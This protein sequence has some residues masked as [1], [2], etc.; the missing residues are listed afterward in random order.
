M[1]WLIPFLF[2]FTA[3]Q[4]DS[5]TT[6]NLLPNAGDGVDWGS[7]STEQ[8]NPGNSSGTV[9]NGATIN[10]F[11]VTCPASQ[12]NCGYKYSVG[13]D[14]EV[15]GTATL[16]VDDIPLT[17]NTRTQEMLDNGITL[18]SY[19]DVANCDSQPGN[20]EGK[21][22]N[23]DSHTVTIQLKDSS[24]DV[25]STTTQTRTEIVGFQG[26]CNGYP[27]NNSG[28]QAANCGQ[29]NDQVIYNNHG[30][31]KVDWSWSGT[32]NNTGTG[33]RGGPNLLGAALTMTYDDTVLNQDASDSLDQ[34][35]DDLGDLD[36]QVFDDVQEF[37]F[38]EQ[39]TF[40]EEPQFEMEM[41]MDMPMETFQFA[42]EFVEEFFMEMDQEFMMEPEGMELTNGP[43]ILFADDAMMDEVYEESN[44]IVATFLP[45]MM[46]EEEESF[47]QEKPVMMTDT[48]QEEEMIEE[49]PTMITES[50][51]QEEMIQEKP[52]MVTESFPQEEMI[53]EEMIEEEM[54]EEPTEMAEEEMI[55]EEP[56]E[57]AEEESVEEKPTKMVQA[58]D[59]KKKEVKEKKLVSKTAK[60]SVVQTK[61]IKEQKAIQQKKALVKNL[62]KVMEKVDKDI[63][64]ISKNLQIKNIIKL[65]AMT[66]E[67]ES[68]DQYQATSFYKPKDIYLDQLNMVDNRLIYT[69]KSLAT[70]IQNDKMEIKARKLM[71]INSRKQQLL[72]ELEVLKNG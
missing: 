7:T 58:K 30:S 1:K 36:N 60:K 42:E 10:G 26:N 14:F 32:D 41:P 12:A 43:M 37:F 55:E 31:N 68:L 16:S 46:P 29:Y 18:N 24:G 65:Q 19:V 4:A 5:I 53:E 17:N 61:K 51:P 22:G 64:N 33:Q 25:L 63:K 54:L 3:A 47:A 40:D 45:M 70:Y 8:I 71:E 66:S 15:T 69:N 13:G 56:T 50:F 44:E 11:D 2:L 9:S 27:G 6:G 72:I 28:G 38:E 49:E 67:Q 20:C 35:Q 39:F 52:A 57:M 21:T 23:A 48:F 34:V 59:E 62:A